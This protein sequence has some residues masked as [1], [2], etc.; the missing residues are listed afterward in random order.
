M[1]PT[2]NMERIIW[3]IILVLGVA[4]VGALAW[5]SPEGIGKSY[6]KAVPAAVDPATGQARWEKIENAAPKHYFAAEKADPNQNEFRLST[7]RTIGLWFAAIMTLAIF[8]FMY[9]DNPFYKFAEAVLVGV[10]AAYWM[11]I[12]FWD[13]IVPNLMGRLAPGTVKSIFIPGLEGRDTEAN[14]WYLI[15]LALGIMLL[16]RLSP[17]GAWIARWPLAFVIGTTAGIRLVGFI[18]ADFLTQIR[19]TVIPLV[20]MTDVAGVARFDFWASL[21]NITIVFGVLACLTYFF[22]SFEHKGIVGKTAR[23]G[24]WF[25][26]ITFG[27]AFGYTVM[28]RITLLAGRLEFL[29]D[30]WLWLIDPKGN[31]AGI[32]AV[33]QALPMLGL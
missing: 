17:K 30:D 13:M 18:H 1:T 20:V 19:A 28:G 29:F 27:A 21:A 26:M 32:E 22:F 5:K 8:S 9:K 12:G 24:I 2:S 16:W 31:R 11:V 23:V 3:S 7:S 10:S 15:P 14:Y 33:T 6:V 25:L 4:L